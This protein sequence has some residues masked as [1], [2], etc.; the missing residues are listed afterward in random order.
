MLDPFELLHMK[1]TVVKY[2]DKTGDLINIEKEARLYKE[3]VQDRLG[4]DILPPLRLKFELDFGL[5]LNMA[6][7][8]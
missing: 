6:G 5:L 3:K 8:S 7:N 2:F 4:N 1:K